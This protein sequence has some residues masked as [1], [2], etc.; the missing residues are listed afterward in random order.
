MLQEMRQYTKS[1][2]SWV[3]VIPLVISFA[4]WGI[5][6][7]FRPATHDDVATVGGTDVSQAEFERQYRLRIRELSVRNNTPITPDTAREMGLG[8]T[9]LEAL[10]SQAALD[11]LASQLGLGV[12]D[13]EVSNQIHSMR[14]FAGPLGAFDKQTFDQ[15]IGEQG[16]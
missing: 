7:V 10:V 13:A 9:L 2:L 4:A 14:E 11:N 12:S 6:D 16:Y 8:K 3:F 5:N 15:R 1:W